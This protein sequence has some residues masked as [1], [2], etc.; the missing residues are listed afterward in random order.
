VIGSGLGKRL[1][2]VHWNVVT[3]I[4]FAWVVTLPAAAVV[5]GGAAWAASSGIAGLMVVLV[6]GLAVC[7]GLF[8]LARRRPVSAENVNDEAVD[9]DRIGQ[10]QTEGERA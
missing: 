5:G 3:R 4:A 9:A 2:S 1:A 10:R 6:G 8:L 7:V